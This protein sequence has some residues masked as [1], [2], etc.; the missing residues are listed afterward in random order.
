[1]E[2][3]SQA[4]ECQQKPHWASK[5]YN[6]QH[7]REYY[8]KNKER[9]KQRTREY[10]ENNKEACNARSMAY[11]FK[12]RDIGPTQLCGCGCGGET[13]PN[14]KYI[15]GHHHKGKQ[16]GEDVRAKIIA[17]IKEMSDE[18]R[19][20]MKLKMS[21]SAKN[22]PPMSEETLA[23]FRKNA[24][25]RRGTKRPQEV[26]EK[27][28]QNRV[29]KHCGSDHRCWNGGVSL[30]YGQGW[31]SFRNSIKKRDGDQC[32]NPECCGSGTRLA[33]HHIDYDKT[34]RH[35]QNLITV[36]TTCNIKANKNRDYWMSLYS[37]ITRSFLY[38]T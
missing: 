28:S 11:Y 1:V 38:N 32:M 21:I 13:T 34:N 22:K 30:I 19:A 37:G 20:E 27:I 16:Y 33:V 9:I 7:H 25:A 15:N 4:Q 29:G 14:R 8:L 36:C 18:A 17:G 2:V 24:E 3:N 12:K 6:Q 10:Y 31:R 35:P 5:E 26:G 23:K